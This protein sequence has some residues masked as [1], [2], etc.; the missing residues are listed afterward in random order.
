MAICGTIRRHS[1]CSNASEDWRRVQ[2]KQG[3]AGFNHEAWLA[4]ARTHTPLA[5]IAADT[6]F[7]D[8]AHMT[9]SVKDV[10]GASPGAWRD[11]R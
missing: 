8:Q 10:T 4:I 9:R 6:G 7:A 5:A 3:A 11:P 1:I 2:Q